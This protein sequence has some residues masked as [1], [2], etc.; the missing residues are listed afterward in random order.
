MKKHI[1]NLIGGLLR[2]NDNLHE[3]IGQKLITTYGKLTHSTED[4]KF[5]K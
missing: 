2:A 4:L 3:F 1:I 5:H